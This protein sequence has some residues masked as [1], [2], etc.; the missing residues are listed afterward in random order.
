METPWN[1]IRLFKEL[2]LESEVS[3]FNYYQSQLTELIGSHEGSF[4]QCGVFFSPPHC[5]PNYVFARDI[6]EKG[7]YITGGQNFSFFYFHL[8]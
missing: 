1:T 4:V 6:G 2:P 3:H 7:Y 8:H 5:Y